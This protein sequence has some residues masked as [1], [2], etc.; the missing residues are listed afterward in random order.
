[1]RKRAW[2]VFKDSMWEQLKASPFK[3]T[4]LGVSPI[5]FLGLVGNMGVGAQATLGLGS[6]FS[7]FGSFTLQHGGS[8]LTPV[9]E[10]SVGTYY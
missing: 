3:H 1:M 5:P 7:S 4:K 9:L 8:Q 2:T 6:F 10:G